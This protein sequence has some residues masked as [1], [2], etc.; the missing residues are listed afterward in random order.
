MPDAGTTR[1]TVA[2]DDPAVPEVV[3][4]VVKELPLASL[5]LNGCPLLLL[6]LTSKTYVSPLTKV[7]SAVVTPSIAYLL[8][9]DCTTV[10]V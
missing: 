8:P 7:S 3:T 4:P 9:P 5:N 6:S 2:P 10:T 1:V